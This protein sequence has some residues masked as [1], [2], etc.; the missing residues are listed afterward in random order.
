MKKMARHLKKVKRLLI[1]IKY[2]NRLSGKGKIV[3]DFMDYLEIAPTSKIILNGVLRLGQYRNSDNGRTSILRMDEKSVLSVNGE[4]N[5]GY[6]ADIVLFPKAVLS[7]GKGSYINCDCKIRCHREISIGEHCAISHDFTIMDSDAHSLNGL[8]YRKP[9]HIG[10]HV[11]IGTRVTVLKGV[12]IGDGAI[13]AAGSVVTHDIPERC[14]AA[15]IPAK[16]V[17]ENVVWGD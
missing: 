10:N 16:V 2:R 12:T 17:K 9:V 3:C 8:V 6:G 1:A 11:W 7:L 4:F 5:F 13:L 14:M 15:G